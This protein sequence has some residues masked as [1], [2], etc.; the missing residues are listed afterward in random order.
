[1]SALPDDSHRPF[2]NYDDDDDDYYDDIG[3]NDDDD[4]YGD[5]EQCNMQ[6]AHFKA[7]SKRKAPPQP[8]LAFGDD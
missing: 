2:D 3:N 4:E 6:V 8:K 1:M 5:V 7:L